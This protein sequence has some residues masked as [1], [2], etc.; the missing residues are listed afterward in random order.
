[1]THPE[2]CSQPAVL[3]VEDDFLLRESAAYVLE[4]EGFETLQ[5]SDATQALRLL[6]ERSDIG[7][8]FTDVHMPGPIDGLELASLVRRRWPAVGIA[9]TSGR[10]RPEARELPGPFL[11]KPYPPKVLVRLLKALI[12]G[13]R[14]T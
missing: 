5:A 10:L 6:E 7:A 1:M 4:S 14:P 11:P 9:V 13:P 2:K 8:L 3:V 12:P